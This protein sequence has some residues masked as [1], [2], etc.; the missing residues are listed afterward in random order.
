M[1]TFIKN[2]KIFSKFVLV[3]LL[4]S[5]VVEADIVI[6]DTNT[7]GVLSNG[8][9]NI[10]ITHDG[11]ISIDDDNIKSIE[12]TGTLLDGK[13]IENYGT[14]EN[15]NY[16]IYTLS[17]NGTILNDINGLINGNG[18]KNAIKV[19][20]DN[21]GTIINNGLISHT[22]GIYVGNNGGSFI[23]NGNIKTNNNNHAIYVENDNNGIIINKGIIGDTPYYA[24][25][26]LGTNNGL[27]QND[28]SI[29]FKYVAG[30]YVRYGN[31]GNILNNG[32]IKGKGSY[33]IHVDRDSNEG[34]ITN[35]GT[36]SDIFISGIYVENNDGLITNNGTIKSADKGI[37]VC[38]GG[39]GNIIN[40]G[41][42]KADTVVYNKTGTGT[43]QNSGNLTGSITT[44]N[45]DIMNKGDINLKNN[46]LIK[47]KTYTQNNDGS[48]YLNIVAGESRNYIET[49][50]D[51]SFESST[52]I[53]IKLT[54][55]SNKYLRWFDSLENST[56][57]GYK[58][59]SSTLANTTGGNITASLGE[60]SFIDNSVLFDF[61][62]EN[63][64]TTLNILV[65]KNKTPIEDLMS[66]NFQG[67]Q[68]DVNVA[69]ALDTI[70]ANGNVD[71]DIDNFL[72]KMDNLSTD[73]EK[74]KAVQS[75][76]PQYATTLST[77]G[78]QIALNINKVVQARQANIRGFSSGDKIFSDK[79]IWIKPFATY[80]K[81]KDK[82]GISGFDVSTNGLGVGA[83]GENIDGTRV[84]LAFFY[85]HAKTNT[86]KLPQNT[87]LDVYSLVSYG[88]KPIIDDKTYMFYQIGAN[89]QKTKS[90][91]IIDTTSQTAA[92]DFTAMNYM[93]QVKVTT[94]KKIHKGLFFIPVIFTT[95]TYYNSPSYTENGAGGMGLSVD[96]FNSQNLFIGTGTDLKY[97]FG[98]NSALLTNILVQ[99]NIIND[100]TTVTSSFIGAGGIAFDTE[101][102]KNS[103]WGYEVGIGYEREVK[104]DISLDIKY[105]LSG[106]GRD[107][108]NH[109]A[110]AKVSWK[111]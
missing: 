69:K 2:K 72:T 102:I 29:T 84:G 27:I 88:S 12:I 109:T 95:Y 24:I 60:E 20:H 13:S 63:N 9:E 68:S 41:I 94:E 110:T 106:L 71:E 107:F 40:S 101:G 59:T 17:N 52:K 79:N 4:F 7:T 28:N 99:Y 32:N 58:K 78:T 6:D 105:D 14:I 89:M 43:L 81:Q 108:I 46:Y 82:D 26:I 47:S 62:I 57:E 92:A 51:I 64:S 91:R 31:K 16:A 30:I 56:I 49:S 75:T 83:D 3:F 18:N 44:P 67:S 42:I 65:S 70:F 39:N 85:T 100:D 90:S 73:K 54:N 23:N 74:A 45:M 10:T 35:N 111:F 8:S 37:E 25:N 22:K 50:S 87:D 11:N 5:V 104:E 61:N 76:V 1:E 53:N 93:A 48:L 97:K 55:A 80:A 38:D 103:P 34:N 15:K 21:N 66:S 98:D 36:I 77:I 96:S 33:G 86:N 19:E